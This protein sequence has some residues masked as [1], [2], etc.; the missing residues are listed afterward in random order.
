MSKRKYTCKDCKYYKPIDETKGECFGHIVPADMPVE[1][2]P[3]KAF[4][5]REDN[6]KNE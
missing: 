2:C 4:E 5:P 3:A 1:Q 6:D